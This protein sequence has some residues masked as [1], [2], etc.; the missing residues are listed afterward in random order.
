MVMIWTKSLNYF[1]QLTGVQIIDGSPSIINTSIQ[2]VIDLNPKNSTTVL[3][4][5]V[6]SSGGALTLT[7]ESGKTFYITSINLN[8][9]KDAACDVA[10]GNIDFQIYAKNKTIAI[11]QIPVI[12]LTAQDVHV[13]LNFSHP[14]ECVEGQIGYSTSTSF[15]AGIFRKTVAVTGYYL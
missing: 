9:C 11:I 5:G 1:R 6:S 3:G 10:T 12:T 13:P 2:P 7:G 15:T 8:V 14:I 4:G